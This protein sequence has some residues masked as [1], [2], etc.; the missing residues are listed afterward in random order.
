MLCLDA[1][2]QMEDRFAIL[3]ARLSSAALTVRSEGMGESKPACGRCLFKK[4]RMERL[5]WKN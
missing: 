1:H 4:E 5:P 3:L 2:S